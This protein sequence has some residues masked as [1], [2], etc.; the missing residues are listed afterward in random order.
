[1]DREQFIKGI[2]L[3]VRDSAISG[4]LKS[5]VEPPGRRPL[6]EDM[7]LSEWFNNLSEQDK[8]MVKKII[9]NAVDSSVF[10]FLAVL[11]GVRVI[12]EGPSKGDFELY[13]VNGSLRIRLNET[14]DEYLH[15]I[16]QGLK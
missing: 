13:Y 14:D 15:D 10:G 9:E 11:D 2:L 12:E 4:T 8:E 1:M 3:R 6:K 16:Y 7:V 5:L